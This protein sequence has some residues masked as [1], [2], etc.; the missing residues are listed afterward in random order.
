[1]AERH[2]RDR[3]CCDHFWLGI[4][5]HLI[6]VFVL[7][8]F[9]SFGTMIYIVNTDNTFDEDYQSK[10]IEENIKSMSW[11]LNNHPSYFGLNVAAGKAGI[12]LT[13][14]LQRY[15]KLI[16]GL[17]KKAKVFAPDLTIHPFYVEL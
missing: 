7:I 11:Y 15:T 16:L 6:Y 10:Q 13:D 4:F 3:H 1:M 8:I 12:N 14:G 5:K 17:E 9:I 2:L